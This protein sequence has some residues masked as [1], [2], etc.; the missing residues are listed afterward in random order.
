MSN[1]TISNDHLKISQRTAKGAIV[2]IGSQVLLAAIQLINMVV[3]SRLLTP[4]DFGLMAM[5]TSVVAFVALFRDLGL[6]TATIQC[7]NLDQDTASGL[8]FVNIGTALVLISLLCTAAPFI[9]VALNDHRLTAVITVSSGTLLIAAL[10]AQHAAQFA[11]DLKFFATQWITVAGSVAGS[12][13]AISLAASGGGYW[14]LLANSWITAVSQMILLWIW[15]PW[16]PSRVRNWSKIRS[17]LDFGF[18]VTAS[19]LIIYFSRQFDK[20][21]VG[22][23]LGGEELGYYSR[24]YAI[25]LV[26]QTLISGPV[27][28]VL[29]PGL[30]R[31]QEQSKDWCELLISA[32]RV[33]TIFTML[34]AALLIA[35]ADEI[36]EIVLGSQ[37]ESSA[38]LVSIFGI[39]MIA[40][41]VMNQNS[42]IYISLGNTKRMLA[43][44][45]TTLPIYLGCIVTGLAYG[46]EGVALGFSLAQLA[47]CVPSVFFA[48]TGTP[49]SGAGLVRVILPIGLVTFITI[50]ASP[51][52]FIPIADGETSVV[53]AVLNLA[54][55]SSV[56]IA[57][58]VFV[59]W[60]DPEYRQLR[61]TV[62]RFGRKVVILSIQRAGERLI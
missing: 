33:T 29:L 50:L 45:L 6:S 23:R 31:L 4:T 3:L 13:G 25:L 46:V 57:G 20:L 49:V 34:V 16:R 7:Q 55:T 52:L 5:S 44:Q 11:R 60:I 2:T 61:G 54:I 26:P 58:A 59:L 19:S 18:S 38:D 28:F 42:W 51:L 47:L 62:L 10:A 40:R 30:S 56:F 14:A 35:N 24:A 8:F 37:W 17:A 9:A 12:I 1:H 15:S 41:A 27:S 32:V 39:S 21:L 53:F 43:W 36:V 48:A 22:H